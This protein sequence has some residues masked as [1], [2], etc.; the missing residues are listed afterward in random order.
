MGGR[1]LKAPPDGEP[2]HA[3]GSLHIPP[4]GFSSA[5]TL[6]ICMDMTVASSELEI[7]AESLPEHLELNHYVE[8]YRR[9]AERARY[10]VV[11]LMV[12]SV[13]MLVAQWNTMEYSWSS[14]RYQS[15]TS[16]YDRARGQP[17][18]TA[19]KTVQTATDGRYQSL[20][21][22]A[23]ILDEYRRLRVERVSIFDV[24][25]IG[26]AIDVNDLG[27]FSGVAN[28]LLFL[29]LLFAV[30]RE[31]ENLYLALFKVRRLHDRGAVRGGE[32]TANYLYHALAMSQVFNAPPTL[33]QW[34]QSKTKRDIPHIVFVV[35][36]LVQ[37]YIVYSNYRTAS[38]LHWY[39]RAFVQ[40]MLPQ[41]V[42]LGIVASL[43]MIAA[44]YADAANYR[45][46]SAFLHLNPGLG[47]VA[48]IPWTTWVRLRILRKRWPDYIQRRMWAQ[49]VQRLELTKERVTGIVPV[50]HVRNIEGHDITFAEIQAMCATLKQH[51]EEI[52]DRECDE[53]HFVRVSIKSS[54]L[55]HPIW[56]VTA[57]FH[58]NCTWKT[59]G[60]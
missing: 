9:S 21:E 60:R 41:F 39:R 17:A 24:P 59:A 54:V 28:T 42:L 18:G 14:K 56:T 2:A 55:H 43:A 30:M 51:A 27:L 35:P 6:L 29:L 1:A 8:T 23:A 57:D 16:L 11:T 37:S 13:V 15:L 50:S 32:S 5:A 48:H 10:V 58:I 33:A 7:A 19:D 53:Y 12:F 22:V 40:E 4:V 34:R 38:I 46:R 45:W 3:T 31:Y 25:G 20:H 26:I 49:V 44:I 36:V 52:A 47:R